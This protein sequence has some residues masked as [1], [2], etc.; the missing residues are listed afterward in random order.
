MRDQYLLCLL[1]GFITYL[2]LNINTD[3]NNTFYI[4]CQVKG[5]TSGGKGG[6]VSPKQAGP[7]GPAVM[8]FELD[9]HG[10]L[11]I[12]PFKGADKN[13]DKLYTDPS[14]DT[15]RSKRNYIYRFIKMILD[16][17]HPIA[18]GGGSKARLESIQMLKDYIVW[19]SNRIYQAIL[20][21]GDFAN[22]TQALLDQVFDETAYRNTLNF[23]VVTLRTELRALIRTMMTAAGCGVPGRIG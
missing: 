10:R 4:G 16:R 20:S 9:R 12:G 15:E 1:I 8:G 5:G 21:Y 6:G 2:I 22:W 19:I 13:V 7:M 18:V 11:T 3:I 17:L 23:G 14:D